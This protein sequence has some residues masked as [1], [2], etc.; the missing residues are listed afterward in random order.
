[1]ILNPKRFDVILTKN[2]FGDVISNKASV[3]CGSIG[4]LSSASIGDHHAM[5]EPIQGWYPDGAGKNIA[6]P[7]TSI[8]NAAMLL[9]HFDL[10]NEAE[11]IKTAVNRS[12]ELAIATPDLNDS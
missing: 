11:L 7:I 5:F 12:L 8:L 9:D 10:P 1:M 6:N 3:I 4:L 2:L